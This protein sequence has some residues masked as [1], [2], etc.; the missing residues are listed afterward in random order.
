MI[1]GKGIAKKKI[2]TKA[3]AAIATMTRERSPV[4]PDLPTAHEKALPNFEAYTWNAF[5]LPKGTPAPI[6]QKLHQATLQAMD[7]PAVRDRLQGLGAMLV[8]P[9]RRSPDSLARFVES[10]IAKWAEPIR[11]SGVSVE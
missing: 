5:F 11:S 3:A 9:E 7:T 8:A 2:A 1:S 4:L 10:E 6:A